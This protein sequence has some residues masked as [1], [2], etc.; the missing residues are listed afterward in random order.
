M[1]KNKEVDGLTL[2]NDR[3]QIN[4]ELLNNN[5]NNIQIIQL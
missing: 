5:E 4:R 1:R 2:F 3:G